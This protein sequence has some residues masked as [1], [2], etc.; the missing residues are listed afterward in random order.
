MRRREPAGGNAMQAQLTGAPGK[1]LDVGMEEEL[2]PS[3]E[4]AMPSGA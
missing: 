2:D 1:E 4:A 3:F